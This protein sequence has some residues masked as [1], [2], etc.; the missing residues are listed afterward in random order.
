MAATP[1]SSCRMQNRCKS[2]VVVRRNLSNSPGLLGLSVPFG[3]GTADEP[4][5]RRCLPR[6]T[7]HSEILAR[8]RRLRFADSVSTEMLTERVDDTPRRIRVIGD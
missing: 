3:I 8:R 4:E 2:G 5:D 1:V 6:S 7:E